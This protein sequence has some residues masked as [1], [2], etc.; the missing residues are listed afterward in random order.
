MRDNLDKFLDY[1]RESKP[2]IEPILYT[3]TQ[4]IYADKILSVID[5][6]REVFEHVLYQDACYRLEVPPEEGDIDDFIKDISRFKNRD[7][8][9][10]ILADSNRIAFLMTPENSLPVYA[11]HGDHHIDPNQK[12]P[13]FTNLIDDIEELK[14]IA[15]VRPKLEK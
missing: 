7:I 12:D 6:A 2:D 3:K 8:K 15:D 4:K 10:S 11:Y 1:L 9:R 13:Y 14:M 5:P